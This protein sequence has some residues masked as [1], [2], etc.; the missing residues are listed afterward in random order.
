MSCSESSS[1]KIVY[2]KEILRAIFNT[3]IYCSNSKV[4]IAYIF[5]NSTVTSIQG[6][7]RMRS[8]RVSPLYSVDCTMLWYT[9]IALSR[10]PFGIEYM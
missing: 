10:K 5:E 1:Y 2:K 9:E 7:T 6:G 4:G 3:R 8:Y